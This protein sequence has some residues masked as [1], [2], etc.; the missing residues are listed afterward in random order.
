MISRAI[1]DAID[2]AVEA[3]VEAAV[4]KAMK[5]IQKDTIK[6]MQ[7]FIDRHAKMENEKAVEF[8][9]WFDNRLAKMDDL[10]Q[11]NDG[12]GSHD[13][14]R[15]GSRGGGGE[16]ASASVERKSSSDG[17]GGTS[18]SARGGLSTPGEMAT[19]GSQKPSLVS[20]DDL[21][22][23][24]LDLTTFVGQKGVDVLPEEET[25]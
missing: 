22:Q 11:Q 3:A 13:R 17:S 18:A 20:D 8:K 23:Y 21:I 2:K 7:D 19:S 15:G 9:R 10:V 25:G 14:D 6:V 5:L 16:D 1:Q 24:A 12:G 4:H